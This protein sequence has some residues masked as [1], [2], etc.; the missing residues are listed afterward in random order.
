MKSLFV[1]LFALTTSITAFADNVVA[2]KPAPELLVDAAATFNLCP[3][4]MAGCANKITINKTSYIFDY[5]PTNNVDQAITNLAQSLI[6]AC[7]AKKLLVSPT[8]TAE[9]YV[10]IEK[11]HFPNP[12]ADF[13]VFKITYLANVFLP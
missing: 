1:L 8:F 6:D 9:G 13:P 10:V 4:R 11:G 7:K 12:M 3:P 5:D 2:P